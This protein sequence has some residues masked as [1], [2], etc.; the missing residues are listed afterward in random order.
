MGNSHVICYSPLLFSFVVFG[1]SLMTVQHLTQSTC[2]DNCLIAQA[3]M[4]DRD[5]ILYYVDQYREFQQPKMEPFSCSV[6]NF[7][8][9]V[10]QFNFKICHSC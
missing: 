5:E 10:G 1:F 8:F 6:Y 2:N 3:S 7:I 9:L 4:E